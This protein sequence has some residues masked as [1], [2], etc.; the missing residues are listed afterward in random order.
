[1]IVTRL[2]LIDKQVAMT[3]ALRKAID[4]LQRPDLHNM[5]DG[6]MEIDGQQVFAL[7]QRY[8]TLV[9]D[10]PTIEYHRAYLDVQYIVS[11]EEII[12]WTPIEHMTITEPYNADRDVCLGT[13]PQRLLTPV[14][15]QAG[16]L[17]VLYPEDG[18]AP[19]MAAGKPSRV[20]KVVVK[21]AVQG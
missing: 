12:G 17:A 20:F 9:M 15:L 19:R 2:N 1:M 21:V 11:G 3:S 18:H 14:H 16:Q 10:A 8:E 6:R 13:V 7:L 5:A 4:F